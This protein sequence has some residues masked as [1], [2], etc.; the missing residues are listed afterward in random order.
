MQ[1]LIN[2][3]IGRIMLIAA[4]ALTVTACCLQAPT[5]AVATEDSMGPLQVK[6]DLKDLHKT[7]TE[8]YFP[9]GVGRDYMGGERFVFVPEKKIRAYERVDLE[10]P[11]AGIMAA[12]TLL[13]EPGPTLQGSHE[14][15]RMDK[16][17]TAMPVDDKS[18]TPSRAP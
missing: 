3:Q 8:K 10:L 7:S 11:L 17:L 13:A 4:I 1:E 5:A 18:A 12:P 2:Q 9:G 14:L 15:P 6:L 16:F